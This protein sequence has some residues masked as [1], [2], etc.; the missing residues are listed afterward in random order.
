MQKISTNKLTYF[1]WEVKL[2][3]PYCKILRY[4]KKKSLASVN[5]VLAR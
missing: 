2:E 1:G 4:V 3:A 5:E